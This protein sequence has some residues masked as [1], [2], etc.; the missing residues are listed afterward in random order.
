MINNTYDVV[1]VGAGHAG[2]EAATASAR[3]GAKTLLVT[4]KQSDLGAMSCNPA[5][6]GIGKGH[7]VREIDAL[8]GLM[9]KIIDKAGIQFRVLN[10]S[11]GPAVQGPRAQADRELYKKY[12][13]EFLKNYP[14]L[15]ITY[16]R[17]DNIIL[18]NKNQVEKVLLLNNGYIFTKAVVITTGTFLNGKIHIGTK[19]YSGGRIEEDGVTEL[20]KFFKK[21]NFSLSRLKTG[22]PARLNKNT[23]NWSILEKQPGDNPPEPFSYLNKEITTEQ[24]CCYITYTNSETHK[25]IQDNINKSAIFNGAISSSGPRYCPSIEDK[26]VRFKDKESHQIFLEPEGLNL[27]TIYPNGLSTSL[28]EE[29]QLSFLRSIKGLEDVEIIKY[30][31]AVEYDYIDPIE[32][33]NTLE[34]KKVQNLFLA[35]QINGTTG[36]EEAAGQG[37]VAGANA[38][39]NAL[40]KEEKLILTRYNSYIGV[41]I[42]DLINQ[43][44]TEPYRMFTGRAE[45]RIL[46]RSDNADSRLTEL[47]HKVG[48]VL[49]NRFNLYKE[50]EKLINNITNKLKLLQA[51]PSELNKRGIKLNQDGIKRS[52]L[53][54][55]NHNDISLEDLSN[56]WPI[57][58]SVPKAILDIIVTNHLYCKFISKQQEEIKSFSNDEKI[59]LPTN[60]NYKNIAGLSAELVEKFLKTKPQTLAAAL[61]IR[62]A[63]P[64]SGIA[65]YNYLKKTKLSELYNNNKI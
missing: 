49:D 8:D 19:S 9:A 56:I 21:H 65:I 41:M 57:L 33:L 6:G 30:G 13:N 18:N 40:N 61:R 28:P 42:D 10:K 23:I 35:G 37:L 59:I 25:I 34:T 29:V 32:L 52:V 16:D 15:I 39:I 62:G 17:V 43:G 63:T 20:S 7:I 12:T 45:Y 31:Y 26:I 50:K 24:I 64:A 54:L 3:I 1:I 11:K 46:L 51:T 53:D 60:L 58:N 55:L 44:V 48:V 2:V 22:T 4:L 27:N 38:A 36:Y 47:G 14:N 5:I